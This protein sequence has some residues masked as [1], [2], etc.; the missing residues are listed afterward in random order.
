MFILG[1]AFKN[2]KVETTWKTYVMIAVY[3][4]ILLAI[5][6][7][8]YKRST[9]TL[10]EYMLGGRDLGP[11]VTALSAGASD[12]SGWM[13]MGLPGSVYSTGL[14]ATWIATGLTIGAWLNYMLVASR[15]RIYTE[16][17][18]NAITLPDYFEKRLSDNTRIVKVISGLVII[19]FFTLYTHSG[20]VAGGV[21]FNSAFGIDYHV[22]L[23]IAASIV[24][25]YT[26]FGGYLAV[27]LTDFFQGVIMILALVLVPI[28]ALLK[29]N[30][31]DTFAEVG[32]LKPTNLDWFKGTTTVGIISL[33]AWG[34]GYFGQPHI[35]VRFMSIKSHK[36]MPK[37]RKIG[38]SWMAISL[39]GACITG[40][41]G[42]AF[43]EQTNVKV[44]NPETIFI[45]MSQILFH[46]LIAGF[47]L[48]AILAAIMSTISSQLLVT[49]SALTQ[50]FYMLIRGKTLQ[51]KDHE[52]E[53]VLVGC[54]SVLIVSIV[55]MYIAWNPNDTILNLVGNA[56]A[57]FGAAFGPLVLLSL[58]WKRLTKYGAIA[59]ILSGSIV[60]IFWIFMKDHGGIFEFYEII[61]GFISSLVLTIL[62][63]LFTKA[64]EDIKKFDEMEK[65][66][67]N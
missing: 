23:L 66:L 7:Y 28:V 38:I 24:I 29:L 26:L 33:L 5:G 15:L 40:L 48:A 3:F 57:G 61:P 11:L 56:W 16:L 9:S 31:L 39:I 52:K 27:S 19:I 8:A 47:F 53:F 37:A 49:S 63:S 62:V 60:V 67:K 44:D 55:A 12:M 41:L 50:D 34:L 64:P 35:I 13:I 30:G 45:V 58:Y 18:D 2:V 6:F 4:A 65:I 51:D 14:S 25:L 54:L 36:L 20:M 46:P 43:V 22:G 32:Q 1:N 10:D 17:T 42:I 21:L 59:G